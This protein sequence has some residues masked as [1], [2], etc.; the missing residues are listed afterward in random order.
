MREKSFMDLYLSS[1]SWFKLIIDI[2]EWIIIIGIALL[3]PFPKIS[4]F[5]GLKIF[6]GLLVILGLYLH[7]SAHSVHRAAHQPKHEIKE[8]VTAGVYSKIRH[9]CYTGYI[10]L[11]LGA[12]FIIGSLS[13]LIPIIL[14]SYIFYDSAVKEERLLREKFGKRYEDYMKKVPWRFIPKIF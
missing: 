6:G 12:F 1:K 14:F 13:M 2:G 5:I 9:P 11:Y 4:S 10:F 7:K 8:I 3:F